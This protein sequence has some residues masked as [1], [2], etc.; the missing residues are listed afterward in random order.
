[1]RLIKSLLLLLCSNFMFAQTNSLLWEITAPETEQKSYVFGTI[2]IIPESYFNISDSLLYCIDIAEEIY[3]EI[4]LD[5]IYDFVNISEFMNE[6]FMPNGTLLSQLLSEEEFKLV[7]SK[8]EDINIPLLLYNKIKPMFLSFLIEASDSGNINSDETQKM[9]SYDM[10]INKIAKSNK[11]PVKGLETMAFQIKLF[12]CISLED[13]AQYLLKAI[14]AEKIQGDQKDLFEIYHK[15][16]L[17]ELVQLLDVADSPEQL[18]NIILDKRNQNWIEQIKE[19]SN[20][21]TCL[22][23]FGAAHLVGE[24]G[25]LNLLK[26]NGYTVRPILNL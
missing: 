7:R 2:H 13:Q 18:N 5:Q 11:K 9:V 8:M 25:I 16:D 3:L 6:L 17:K 20:H 21:K 10:E 26:E 24:K 23:A 12:D 15:Q 19:T 14:E 4:E 1:M 22:Y